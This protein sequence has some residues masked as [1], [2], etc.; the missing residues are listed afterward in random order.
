MNE[1]LLKNIIDDIHTER[2]SQKIRWSSSFDCKNTLNDWATYIN[3]YL[4]KATSAAS[5]DQTV[6]SNLIKVAALTVTALEN[7]D[8]TGTFA[9]RHYD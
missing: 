3:I 4:S 9:K 8:S 7:F 1:E 2:E 5:T 6:R